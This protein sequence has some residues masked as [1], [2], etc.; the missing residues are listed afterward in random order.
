M[1][2]IKGIG[3]DLC[4]IERMEKAIAK[5]HFAERVFTQAERET[6]ASRGQ[7]AAQTAAAM[8]AAK[9]AV[10]KALGTGFSGG[11]SVGEI[12]VLHE[13]SGAPCVALSGGARERLS[14][15]GGQRVW[16]SLSHE[17]DMAAAFA[18]IE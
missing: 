14:A 18:V 5:P 1:P 12:E 16:I 6:I 7:G 9:E 2:E 4:G 17:G 8:F 13:Q 15:L 3:V 10:A 11:V